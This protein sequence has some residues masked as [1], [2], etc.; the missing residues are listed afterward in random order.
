MTI[1]KAQGQTFDRIGL[2]LASP[3]FSHGQLYVA[4]SRVRRLSD[5]KVQILNGHRQ[6]QL[7]NDDTVYTL[8][9]VFKEVI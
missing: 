3:V 7:S 1:N 6:G 8:N 2:Y 4:F 5:I 9:V